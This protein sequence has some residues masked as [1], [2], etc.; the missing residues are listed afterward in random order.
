MDKNS[1]DEIS[2]RVERDRV[3]I[4]IPLE[5]LALVQENRAVVIDDSQAM[6]RY[7]ADNIF[8]EEDADGYSALDRL[9]NQLINQLIDQAIEDGEDWLHEHESWQDDIDQPDEDDHD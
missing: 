2:A 4:E 7:V 3:I 5:A 8:G 9:I 1:Q 6:A